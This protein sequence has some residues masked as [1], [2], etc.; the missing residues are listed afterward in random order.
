MLIAGVLPV[1]VD[2]GAKLRLDFCLPGIGQVA[3]SKHFYT[4][5]E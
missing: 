5:T 3:F 1:G 4:D 2:G